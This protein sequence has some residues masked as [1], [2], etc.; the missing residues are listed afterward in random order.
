MDSPVRTNKY[1]KT[2]KSPIIELPK[3]DFS[4]IEQKENSFHAKNSHKKKKNYVPDSPN[5]KNSNFYTP[6][7]VSNINL[8]SNSKVSQKLF[9]GTEDNVY[10]RVSEFNP[11]DENVTSKRLFF[12]ENNNITK[13]S[14]NFINNI[15]SF[16][17]S[18][19]HSSSQLKDAINNTSI[20]QPDIEK[21]FKSNDE[22]TPIKFE[23]TMTGNFYKEDNFI[24]PINSVIT[25]NC[26][27]SP[28]RNNGLTDY[29]E[30]NKKN[31]FNS[32]RK[33]NNLNNSNKLIY[34]A[35]KYNKEVI[36][37]PLIPKELKTQ[38]FNSKS[39]IKFNYQNP[40]NEERMFKNKKESEYCK[41]L[42]RSNDENN[43]ESDIKLSNDNQKINFC[44]DEGYLQVNNEHHEIN[45]LR[46]SFN[47]FTKLDLNKNVD[48]LKSEYNYSFNQNKGND[49]NNV[50]FTFNKINNNCDFKDIGFSNQNNNNKFSFNSNF[51]INLN[52]FNNKNKNSMIFTN[53]NP[54]NNIRENSSNNQFNQFELSNNK[55]GFN[56]NF[57]NVNINDFNESNFED[58]KL[59]KHLSFNNFENFKQN[60]KQSDNE[61]FGIRSDSDQTYQ[62]LDLNY[63]ESNFKIIKLLDEGCFGLVYL[64]QNHNGDLFAIKISKKHYNQ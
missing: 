25:K 51:N 32:F 40:I 9:F 2:D 38:Y 45:D 26:F 47:N 11:L 20:L 53:M 21:T 62:A 8:K 43:Y 12:N 57:K 42:F 55:M 59:S 29:K 50:N 33:G 3:P 30:I 36:C 17:N 48:P 44:S 1:N 58:L 18:S 63:F 56:K 15:S 14:N 54:N 13:K 5:K 60:S 7:K 64:C 10:S 46:I 34:I 23:N 4:V 6:H 41:Q 31:S 39:E 24:S 35:D 37:S 22:Y 16:N 27:E 19:T 28:K 49:S 52:D 61:T